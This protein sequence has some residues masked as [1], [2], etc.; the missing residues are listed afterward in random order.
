MV[1]G[2]WYQQLHYQHLSEDFVAVETSGATIP[3]HEFRFGDSQNAGKK[4]KLKVYFLRNVI[5]ASSKRSF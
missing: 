5:W 3:K 4:R 1:P 2:I